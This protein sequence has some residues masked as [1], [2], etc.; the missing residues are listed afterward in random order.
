VTIPEPISPEQRPARRGTI[1]LVMVAVV[2]IVATAAW[3]VS[4][5]GN[6]VPVSTAE[7]VAQLDPDARAPEGV[8]VR[9]RVLN[10]TTTRGLA[11]RVTNYVRDLGFDVVEY[12]NGDSD[13]KRAVTTVVVHTGNMDWARRLAK[14]LETDSIESVPDSSRYVDLTVLIGSN[15]K[16]PASQPFRP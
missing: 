15:W 16:T 11:R 6:D 9:V 4:T 10:T 3:W 12:G 14:G 7:A 13:D 5:R 2:A 8:R 1:I